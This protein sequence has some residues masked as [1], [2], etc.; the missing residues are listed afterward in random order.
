MCPHDAPLRSEA[1]QRFSVR[2]HDWVYA[3]IGARRLGSYWVRSRRDQDGRDVKT[4]AAEMK[5][6]E[7]KRVASDLP[8]SGR[9]VDIRA[10]LELEHE[11]L[12]AEQEDVVGALAD[13]RDHEL[14]S[15]CSWDAS[16][17]R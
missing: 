10:D 3:L 2:Q 7:V 16:R 15:D 1:C 5:V 14:E 13:P 11:D 8:L 6:L 17:Y 4:L 9:V 12:I